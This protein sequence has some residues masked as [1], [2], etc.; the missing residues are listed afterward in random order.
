MGLSDLFKSSKEI[1]R[2]KR[3]ALRAKEREAER[4]I[5]R[6]ARQVRELEKERAAVW[7]HARELVQ[8]GKRSEA[9][10]LVNQ[11]KVMGVEINRLERQRMLAQNKLSR[12]SAAGTLGSVTSAIAGFADG[13]D[14]DPDKISDELDSISDVEGEIDEMNR[15]VDEAYES[16]MVK[17]SAA[18]ELQGAEATDDELMSELESE[19]ASEV[20]GGGVVDAESSN[21]DINAGRDRLR[22]LLNE[23]EDEPK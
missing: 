13:M 14:V 3:R 15:V 7:A 16:D 20:L 23:S 8:A 22:A 17:A 9:A 21:E 19:A 11:Y 10:R 4:G 12:V 5:S 2:E 1:E 6:L 18:A